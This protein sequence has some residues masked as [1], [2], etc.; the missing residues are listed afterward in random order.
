M[1]PVLPTLI[2]SVFTIASALTR[3]PA[4]TPEISST[5]SPNTTLVASRVDDPPAKR[6]PAF[7]ATKEQVIAA[8]NKLKA[9]GSFSGEATGKLDPATRSAVKAFQKE[10]GLNATGSLNRATLEKMGIP[11]TDKQKQI[12]VTEASLKQPKSRATGP[13]AAPFRASKD[14]IMEAQRLLKSS[15]MYSGDETGKLDD[16]TREALKRFQEAK[17]IKVTGTLNQVTLEKMGIA[18]TDK[19]KSVAQNSTRQ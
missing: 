11:L 13:R 1:K 6:A 12:P 4:A 9:K 2:V 14:Q 10:N 3:V 18:L 19:Q 16:A 15:G 17:G 7:R 5:L 8:Q